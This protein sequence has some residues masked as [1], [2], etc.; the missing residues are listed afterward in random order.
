[1]VEKIQKHRN[2][3]MTDLISMEKSLVELEIFLCI[4]KLS[5]F[6]FIVYAID[7]TLNDTR[8]GKL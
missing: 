3:G 8:Y 7:L 4:T 1:M 5:I 6:R 2:L